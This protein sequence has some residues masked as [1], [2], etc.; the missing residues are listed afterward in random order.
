MSNIHLITTCTNGK[1]G[2]RNS[3]LSLSK[4]SSGRMPSD[5]LINSWCNALSEA[6][7]TSA[8]ICV[9]DLYKGGH[10][11]TVKTILRDYPIDLWVLSAGIGLLHYKDKVVPYKATFSTGYEE[12]I[13]TYSYEYVGKSFHRTWWKK[14]N[15]HSVFKSR[16]PT[17]IAE[18]MNENSRDFFILCGSPDYINAIELDVI[19]GVE[20]L[21]DP[22]KQLL[23]I[24]SKKINSRLG[25]YLYKS[26][27]HMAQYLKCNMLMLNIKLAQYILKEFTGRKLDDLNLLS[28]QLAEK[29]ENIPE[30]E[31]KKGVRRS[32]VEVNQYILSIIQQH[33]GISATQ[34]LRAFRDAGNS[35]EEKRFRATFKAISGSKP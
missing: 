34:A 27:Q 12:S 5:I 3:T 35:F 25:T 11:A 22:N 24:T 18:L 1:N 31:V 20:Y 21:V 2:D 7:K 8:S 30:R 4:Y 33:P 26:N 6:I 14:I 32:P 23:I 19:S 15:E 9:E 13:P 10:W 29:F 16:H 28:Q 17:S